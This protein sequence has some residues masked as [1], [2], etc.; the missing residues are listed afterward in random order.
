MSIVRRYFTA[1]E[2]QRVLKYYVAHRS[3]ISFSSLARQFN[4]HGGH[5]LVKGWYDSW[6]GSI[7]SLKAKPKSGRKRVLD[8]AEVRECIRKRIRLANRAATSI[9]Y[10]Q[11]HE[12][13]ERVTHKKM[14]VRTIRNYGRREGVTYVAT[15]AR[16]TREC[17][18]YI[19]ISFHSFACRV[20]CC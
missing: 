19:H 1:E 14:T 16:T 8:S 20:A 3:T 10:I 17:K 12:H 6:D 7:E 11:L 2:K 5:Q 13:V 9:N 18:L 4:I 15:H